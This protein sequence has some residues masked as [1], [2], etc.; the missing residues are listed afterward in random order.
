[1]LMPPHPLSAAASI[2]MTKQE[3]LIRAQGATDQ[4]YTLLSN[5]DGGVAAVSRPVTQRGK[6]E[7]RARAG[8]MQWVKAAL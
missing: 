7:E 3:L 8:G 1:M 4:D 2:P 5:A 6:G